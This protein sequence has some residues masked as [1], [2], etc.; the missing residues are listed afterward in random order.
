[1]NDGVS[2]NGIVSETLN[3]DKV[4]KNKRRRAVMR[5]TNV[6]S[7]MSW[8]VLVS[9]IVVVFPRITLARGV[10]YAVAD[11]GLTIEGVSAACPMIY[12]NDW[13]FDTPDKNYLWAKASLGEADLRGNIVSRDMWDWRNGYLYK[14]EQGM[15][16]AR[17]S[18]AIARRS[19]LRNIPDP[20]AGSDRAFE[21]PKSGKIED[22]KVFRSPGSDLI[23]AEAR[24]ATPQKPLLVFVGGP[25]NTVANAYLTDASIA[26]KMIVFMTDLRGYNGKDPWANTIVA[27]RCKLINYGAHIWWPQRPEPPA[28]PLERFKELP[29]NEMTADIERIARWFWERSTKKDRPDRDD[30]FADG[31]PIFLVFNPKT[32]TAVQRQQVNGVFNV[33]DVSSESYDLLDAR[34][35]DY[36]QMSEDFFTLLRNPAVYGGERSSGAK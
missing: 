30:G 3:A 4:L 34:R 13:W 5:R 20:V 18:I 8:A 24:K 25:L 36:R 14:L 23:V 10:K 2:W 9:L 32:W 35:L 16:D 33:R 26:E 29:K 27:T 22:T 11:K 12:D 17:K 19:G 31:A 7:L 1:M 21:R 15:E 6:I 28:M